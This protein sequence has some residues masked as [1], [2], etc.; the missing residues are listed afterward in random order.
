MEPFRAELAE[1]EVMEEDPM[2]V[3][4]EA[5]EAD[6][7]SVEE[8]E[9]TLASEVEEA[10]ETPTSVGAVVVIWESEVVDRI[11]PSL[12]MDGLDICDL[13]LK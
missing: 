12:I 5:M 6:P 7:T 13:K 1:E 11:S 10:T 8:V 4:V 3:V 2:L 9:E